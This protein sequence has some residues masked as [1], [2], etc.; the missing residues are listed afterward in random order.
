MCQEISQSISDYYSQTSS[1]WEILSVANPPLQY[2]KYI[3][4]LP[5]IRI[6][7]DLCISWWIY[8]RILSLLELLCLAGL[9]LL[10][11]M[12][13][14]R[15]SEENR[16]P[17]YHM[18]SSDHVLATPLPQPPIAA[19]TTP[20]RINSRRPTFQSSKGT[21]CKFCRAKGHDISVCRKLQKFVQE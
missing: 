15:S 11:L 1:M 13:Q 5:N 16:R 2:P 21:H 9:L 7:V 19:F 6:I 3:E 10:L 14:Y 12:L 8:R 18:T 17:T 20:P 4:L